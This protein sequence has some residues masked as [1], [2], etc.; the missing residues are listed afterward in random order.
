[1]FD[2]PVSW[3]SL[4]ARQCS[5]AALIATRHWTFAELGAA[6][7]AVVSLTEVVSLTSLPVAVKAAFSMEE[8]MVASV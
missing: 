4:K 5:W 1:M 7:V 2:A 6:V 3:I 8:L